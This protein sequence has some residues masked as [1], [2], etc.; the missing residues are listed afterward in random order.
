MSDRYLLVRHGETIWSGEGRYAGHSDIP[1]SE[2]GRAQVR[3]LAR[4]LPGEPLS[5]AYTS[6]LRR[7]VETLE[8]LLEG[9]AGKR[10]DPGQATPPV[11]RRCPELRELHF[12]SWEGQTYAELAVH[13]GAAEVLAGEAAPP[14]GESLTQLAHRLQR[15]LTVL[16]DP[17]S[18]GQR[19]RGGR[20]T[21]LIVTHG[22]PL[23]VLL[24]LLLGLPPAEQWRFQV[25]YASVTEVAW[26]GA[27][28]ARLVRANARCDEACQEEGEREGR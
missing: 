17:S 25:D 18:D 14:G 10:G 8:L 22:G 20:R 24:C 7:A 6:D 13:A 2:T 21:A 5:A 23:R 19:P 16:R 27:T 1:L 11:V 3:R 12:G 4:L 15:F 9:G 28:G 26:D